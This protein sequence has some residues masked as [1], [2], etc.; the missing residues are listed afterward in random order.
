MGYG[1][2]NLCAIRDSRLTCYSALM[3]DLERDAAKKLAAQLRELADKVDAGDE[4]VI[5]ELLWMIARPAI[6]ALNPAAESAR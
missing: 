2:P 5:R 4:Q 3:T 1:L 6:S